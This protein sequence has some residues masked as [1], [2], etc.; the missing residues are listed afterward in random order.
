M[1][2]VASWTEFFELVVSLNAVR[3]RFISSPERRDLGR[4]GTSWVLG[5]RKAIT[6]QTPHART[7]IRFKDFRSETHVLNLFFPFKFIRSSHVLPASLEDSGIPC[8]PFTWY[9]CCPD[10][11]TVTFSRHAHEFV[12]CNWKVPK[13]SGKRPGNYGTRAWSS[14]Q[15]FWKLEVALE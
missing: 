15:P 13:M 4:G 9:L 12:H 8:T 7:S 11:F 14:R 5:H 6:A 10:A 3:E 2:P 1:R